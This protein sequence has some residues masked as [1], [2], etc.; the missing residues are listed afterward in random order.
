MKQ[1]LFGVAFA[2]ATTGSVISAQLPDEYQE[3][4]SPNRVA[5]AAS[6]AAAGTA[7]LAF[8]GERSDCVLYVARDDS[9][10]GA[11]P[12]AWADVKPLAYVKATDASYVCTVP[13]EMRRK[14]GVIRF[15]LV[16]PDESLPYFT[17][18]DYIR[19]TTTVNGYNYDTGIIP[20]QTTG[21]TLDFQVTSDSP[22]EISVFGVWTKCGMMLQNSRSFHCVPG[23]DTTVCAYLSA[24]DLG[25]QTARMGGVRHQLVFER[26]TFLDG[27]SIRDTKAALDTN[28][29]ANNYTAGY[30]HPMDDGLNTMRLFQMISNAKDFSSGDWKNNNPA[31]RIYGFDVRESGELVASLRPCISKE[32]VPCFYDSI[33]RILIK[34]RNKDVEMTSGYTW[35]S[36]IGDVSGGL[37]SAS[38]ALTLGTEFGW[39]EI[40]VSAEAGSNELTLT[41]AGAGAKHL[42]VAHDTEDRG[43]DP[44][45][46]AEVTAV[47]NI[48]AD[49]TSFVYA[50][51][52]K[53]QGAGHTLRFFL[54]SPGG[55]SVYEDLELYQWI[56]HGTAS[57][58]FD[59]GVVPDRTTK[60]ALDLRFNTDFPQE[61]NER[62]VFGLWPYLGVF[63]Q[64]GTM[65]V[66][67]PGIDTTLTDYLLA[68]GAGTTAWGDKRQVLR[69]G[70]DE[71]SYDGVQQKLYN[72]DKAT[73]YA[74]TYTNALIAQ[75]RRTLPLFKTVYGQNGSSYTEGADM[76]GNCANTWLYGCDI[77]TNGNV[78]AKR[79][80][81][82]KRGTMVGLYDEVGDRFLRPSSA[83]TFSVGGGT[84]GPTLTA[85][86]CETS[87]AYRQVRTVAVESIDRETGSVTLTFGGAPLDGTLFAVRNRGGD[88]GDDPADWT[89]IL[90][91]GAVGAQE[92]EKT[93]TQVLP[94]K[95]MRQG[96]AIRFVVAQMPAYETRLEWA[97]NSEGEKKDWPQYI[98]TGYR[99]TV[100][101]EITVKAR[102]K[103]GDYTPFGIYINGGYQLLYGFPHGDNFYAGFFGDQPTVK[104]PAGGKLDFIQKYNG[105]TID[106]TPPYELRISKDGLWFPD[107]DTQ[108]YGAFTP[109]DKW[110]LDADGK[111]LYDLCLFGCKASGRRKYNTPIRIY[112]ATAKESGETVFDLVPVVKNGV[113]CF[114][115]KAHGTFF[116]NS[117]TGAFVAGPDIGYQLDEAV[118]RGDLSDPV[119]LPPLGMALQVR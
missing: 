12:G 3:V 74:G 2:L 8:G 29:A 70:C 52:E 27:E 33:R 93:L 11:T 24:A 5:I 51:P 116:T 117:G 90:P 10:K 106:E 68:Q 64:P 39:R 80:I 66:N 20:K 92:T 36:P 47:T 18:V 34:P 119:V 84:R 79:L 43:T 56:Y 83:G 60:L 65:F 108:A 85:A 53:W 35:G 15:F 54:S 112:S 57:G 88:C 61:L 82:A 114:Y 25:H 103:V 76:K 72:M 44:A 7:T 14:G 48:A 4:E 100:N 32:G 42:Y 30:D 23:I 95:W 110:E 58:F 45:A 86:R 118:A 49:M 91:L 41:F 28:V 13:V 96:G 97:G 99:P 9:D 63:A 37:S 50:I 67:L 1:V 89:E 38:D 81:P 102:H 115:D 113:V 6:D 59:T 78:L 98:Q 87:A 46:W 71:F 16:R 55:T 62:G 107:L 94:R 19:P 69:V 77:V 21:I 104:T 105:K 22:N 75:T 101:C 31:V 17:L 111:S 109:T 26:G 73:L 40:T